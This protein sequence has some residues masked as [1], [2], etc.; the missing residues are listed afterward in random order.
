MLATAWVR[1]T[2][3]WGLVSVGS[4]VFAAVLGFNLIGEG[5][6]LRASPDVQ[7]MRFRWLSERLAGVRLAVEDAVIY[8]ITQFFMGQRL[9]FGLLMFLLGAAAGSF[10]LHGWNQGWFTLP[11]AEVSLLFDDGTTRSTP[12]PAPVQTVEA[13]SNGGGVVEETVNA[14][15]VP[16]GPALRWSYETGSSFTSGPIQ[17][18]EGL[19]YAASADSRLH[20]IEPDGT[21]RWVVE[22][23]ARPVGQPALAPDGTV[24]VTDKEGALNAFSPD[25]EPIWRFTIDPA[26]TA[27]SGPAVAADGTIYYALGSQAGLLQAVSPTGTGLWLGEGET[28]SYYNVPQPFVDS[29]L[30][31]LWD[32][33]FDSQSG[34]LLDLAFPTDVDRYLLGEDGGL[35]MRTGHTLMQ[36]QPGSESPEILANLSWNYT[37]YLAE[38]TLPRETGVTAGTRSWE[39]YTTDMGGITTVF[40][41][42]FS[43]GEGQV[44]GSVRVPLSLGEV[45]WMDADGDAPRA[46]LCGLGNHQFPNVDSPKPACFL[47]ESE[48]HDPIW[49]IQLEKTDVFVGAHYN[50]GMIYLTTED[51]VLHAISESGPAATAGGFELPTEPQPLT[52]PVLVWQLENESGFSGSPAVAADGSVYAAAQDGSVYAVRADGTVQW[53]TQTDPPAAFSPTLGPDGMLYIPDQAG[54]V[55]ALSPTG[56]LAWQYQPSSVNWKAISPISRAPS[57]NLY[58]TVTDDT[59]GYLVSVAPDGTENWSTA[60]STANFY[61]T[62]VVSLDESRVFLGEDIFDGQ[63]GQQVFLETN[64][65]VEEFLVGRNGKTYLRAQNTLFEWQETAGAI[66]LINTIEVAQVPSPLFGNIPVPDFVDV[67]ADGTIVIGYRDQIVWQNEAGEL[68]HTANPPL[69]N[70]ISH[71]LEVETDQT[72][73]TCGWYRFSQQDPV[74]EQCM[75][76]GPGNDGQTWRIT[77]GNSPGLQTTVAG[78]TRTPTGFVYASTTGQ[79]Y[80]IMDEAI[81]A[82]L[83]EAQ[84]QA[85]ASGVQSMA[86]GSGW[87]FET[88]ETLLTSPLIHSDG[89]VYLLTESSTFYIVNPDGSRKAVVALPSPIRIIED[90]GFGGAP[91]RTPIPPIIAQDGSIVA[92]SDDKVYA[93]GLDGTVNWE[94]PLDDVPFSSP[95]INPET[96]LV[97]QLDRLGSLYAISPTEGLLWKHD[98]AEGLRAASPEPVF[99]PNGEIFYIITNGTKGMVE[100]LDLSGNPLW[101]TDL[102]TFNFFRPIQITPDGNWLAVDDNVVNATSGQLVEI[103][104]FEFSIDQFAMGQDGRTY[105]L[106]GNTVIEWQIGPAGFEVLQQISVT[107]PVTSRGIP[108]Y[109]TVSRDQIFWISIFTTGGRTV[110]MWFDEE[111]TVLGLI[112]LVSRDDLILEYDVTNTRISLCSPDFEENRMTCRGYE[113]GSNDPVWQ[114]GIEGIRQARD[115]DYV[116]GTLYVQ[117]DSNRVQAVEL[118]LP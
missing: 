20:A 21:A 10:T 53:E 18:A 59:N 12:T 63:S 87:L 23:P 76:F 49:E 17:G 89:S 65:P 81:A 88:P 114:I 26:R 6:R 84:A 109:L 68:Q 30:V 99:G 43:D 97:Y 33:A 11:S 69:G 50:N 98:L 2:D 80:G 67:S 55:Q 27:T 61:R 91:F 40:W 95:A 1:L 19:L 90:F 48:V 115:V 62:P 96:G 36:W 77:F 101:R 7:V 112:N 70:L 25:G 111:G 57:G 45:V 54:G 51:G 13:S 110:N 116:N 41:I 72:L 9:A 78:G 3:P 113:V 83:A 47:A 37:A 64:L 108:P 73:I 32:D 75:G 94:I 106:A 46:L 58:Y 38:G 5:L 92:A 28:F 52:Q 8:P 24:Y 117:L 105:L 82:A 4:V 100:T 66:E 107:F 15:I 74:G 29:G 34:A 56:E 86:T 60:A 103:E 31:F 104:G 85:E 79:L 35:Y 16:T 102:T 42:D 39:L 93:I 44:V 14:E 118:E 71:F 22:L